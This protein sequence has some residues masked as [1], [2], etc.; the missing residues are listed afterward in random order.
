M[1][2]AVAWD[3]PADGLPQYAGLRPGPAT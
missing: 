1:A 3:R 2:D